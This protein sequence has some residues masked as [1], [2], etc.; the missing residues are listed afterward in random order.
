M[1]IL[2]LIKSEYNIF[3]QLSFDKTYNTFKN[4][5]FCYFK[6]FSYS[7]CPLFVDE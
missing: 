6:F 2:S 5:Y 3:F 4:I 1:V 7:F